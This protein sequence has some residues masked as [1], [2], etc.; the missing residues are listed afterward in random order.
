M[1]DIRY[2]LSMSGLVS[3]VGVATASTSKDEDHGANNA[4]GDTP[5]Y[6]LSK[7]GDPPHWWQIDLKGVYIDIRVA[8]S[9]QTSL[10]SGSTA[11]EEYGIESSVNSVLWLLQFTEEDGSCAEQIRIDELPTM[12]VL[13]RFVRITSTLSCHIDGIV[14][15]TQVVVQGTLFTTPIYELCGDV[16]A[17]SEVDGHEANLVMKPRGDGFWQTQSTMMEAHWLHLDLPAPFKNV[18]TVLDWETSV[19]APGNVFLSGAPAFKSAT[20]DVSSNG[21]TST[22]LAIASSSSGRNGTCDPGEKRVDGVEIMKQPTQIIQLSAHETCSYPKNFLAL[23]ELAVWGTPDELILYEVRGNA[24]ASSTVT[25]R[26]QAP[27]LSL[28]APWVS[29]AVT[30]LQS[31]WWQ[32]DL[33][34]RWTNV[35]VRLQWGKA[36]I[37]STFRVDTANSAEDGHHVKD[38]EEWTTRHT[39]SDMA[40][41]LQARQD[42]M[43]P[44]VVDVSLI[45][46][47]ITEACFASVSITLATIKGYPLCTSVRP[48]LSRASLT[49]SCCLRTYLPTTS[50]V[51]CTYVCTTRPERS[52]LLYSLSPAPGTPKRGL[53]YPSGTVTSS[54]ILADGYGPENAFPGISDLFWASAIA[55]S[56]WWKVELTAE[57]SFVA[58]TIQWAP[59]LGSGPLAARNYYVSSSLDGVKW[60]TDFARI[61][62]ACEAFERVDKLPMNAALL[63]WVMIEVDVSCHP[64]NIVGILR[65]QIRGH[66]LFIPD[67]VTL[68]PLAPIT[69]GPTHLPTSEPTGAPTL[70][71]APSVATATAAPTEDPLASDVP[72]KPFDLVCL[73][74]GEMDAEL[75]WLVPA[76]GGSPISTFRIFKK[77]PGDE[78][79]APLDDD[80]AV[81]APPA[82]GDTMTEEAG[83]LQS[84]IEYE[85][86]VLAVSSA[87]EGPLSESVVCKTEG[88]ARQVSKQI[89]GDGPAAG[90]GGAGGTSF[91]LYIF[92][93][94]VVFLAVVL[95][96]IAVLVTYNSRGSFA[97]YANLTTVDSRIEM[98]SRQHSS[99]RD[100]GEYRHFDDSSGG[101]GR[102]GRVDGDGS[103]GDQLG[104]RDH[105]GHHT[106]EHHRSTHH[107]SHGDHHEAHHDAPPASEVF[108]AALGSAKEEEAPA[109][110]EQVR[111]ETMLAKRR[112]RTAQKEAEAREKAGTTPV[113]GGG[114]VSFN[115]K[116]PRTVRASR[117]VEEA[118]PLPVMGASAALTLAGVEESFDRTQE[119]TQATVV[120]KRNAASAKLQAKLDERRKQ[121]GSTAAFAGNAPE[122]RL[123]LPRQVRASRHSEA[124]AA[125]PPVFG[126]GVTVL[127]LDADDDAADGADAAPRAVRRRRTTTTTTTTILTSEQRKAQLEDRREEEDDVAKRA[128]RRR[129]TT[130]TTMTT[131]VLGWLS[132]SI[133]EEVTESDFVDKLRS[134]VLLCAVLQQ[135]E[136]AMMTRYHV[137]ASTRGD[138]GKSRA[139]FVMIRSSCRR[140]GIDD[141]LILTTVDL[142]RRNLARIVRCLAALHST[143]S[144]TTSTTT[145]TTMTTILQWLTM[146]Y[147]A[148]VTESDFVGKLRSGVLLCTFLQQTE[149][150]GMTRFHRDASTH[151]DDAK[152]RAN[153]VFLRSS[154]RRLNIDDELILTQADLERR[155]VARIVSCLAA[156]ARLTPSID[157]SEGDDD[158]ATR[159]LSFCVRWLQA[160]EYG[161]DSSTL[162]ARLQNGALLCSLLEGVSGA[163]M[164]HFHRSPRSG[165][166]ARA[167]FVLYRA[168][169]R[170]VGVADS[171]VV[172]QE[173]V[174]RGDV[175]RIVPCLRAL[176]ARI[177]ELG[178]GGTYV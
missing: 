41:G 73:G 85:F 32:V 55:P 86:K 166:H 77:A 105:S 71:G 80:I 35:Y 70:T 54:E 115:L 4:V 61:D 34:T 153:F 52:H 3:I 135:T 146:L 132:K 12:P 11:A 154:C 22:A 101:G 108:R 96:V 53:Y 110:P 19:A 64:D 91:I 163:G 44:I 172:R 125:L 169:C 148:E 36:Q 129:R 60:N 165:A 23:M 162:I 170:R 122:V 175:A 141:E 119:E 90:G 42:V 37:A 81:D 137:D 10:Q 15:I 5:T 144:A 75:Q 94:L 20:M 93:A 57:F 26:P 168:A 24:S 63:R 111:K 151:G 74:A 120:A 103:R 49:R 118:A 16:S 21:Y 97:G 112:E 134:G 72:G 109:T 177:E 89:G 121:R 25:G 56:H 66:S 87:G 50:T 160:R 33:G 142:D 114:S 88:V 38:A 83:G 157:A 8:I 133:G 176:F 136:G 140:I 127:E 6:W 102:Y 131:T 47:V 69:N 116:Q 84:G 117:H 43:P 130:T 27:L 174:E 68:P 98:G 95:G 17:S 62:A 155:D 29:D 7:P 28:P 124:P 100:D 107:R 14:G 128:A 161:V 65:I 149:G 123:V 2:P 92:V 1:T 126:A 48:P 59:P 31:Q 82:A 99:R 113:S 9:W 76:D 159:E 152:S 158:D 67:V 39:V 51:R 145:S 79:F 40:C 58:I 147:G 164:E 18:Y 78:S 138:D 156:L 106:T 173:D 178:S 45:R 171:T 104:E 167:N 46:I 139:N 13:A 143:V 30:I 150:A